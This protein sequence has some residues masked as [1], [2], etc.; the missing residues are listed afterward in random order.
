MNLAPTEV[1]AHLQK[2]M[3]WLADL[4]Q[5]GLSEPNGPRLESAGKT[6]RGKSKAVTD[7]PFAE[8]K[9]LVTGMLVV[10][11]ATLEEATEI[12]KGCP[13]YEYDGSVEVRPIFQKG[14]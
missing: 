14:G 4:D 3:V 11:A 13:I 12:A 1:G 5:K 6:V 10:R 7:G 8:A 9:D 2:W